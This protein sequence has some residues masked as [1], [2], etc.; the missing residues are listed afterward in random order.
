MNITLSS[1]TT[2]E[3]RPS[4]RPARR[5]RVLVRGADHRGQ[6]ERDL[7]GARALF[8]RRRSRPKL[9]PLAVASSP[10]ANTESRRAS[11]SSRPPNT[12]S[13]RC[14]TPPSSIGWGVTTAT[15]SSR[16]PG[17]AEAGGDF[18]ELRVDFDV[19]FFDDDAGTRARAELRAFF[20]AARLS[21]ARPPRSL[22][23][24]HREIVR[25]REIV[26]AVPHL[27]P[28]VEERA[29]VRGD[30]AAPAEAS[31]AVPAPSSAARRQNTAPS[32]APRPARTAV[33]RA[34]SPPSASPPCSRMTKA[35]DAEHAARD[36]LR[37]RRRRAGAEVQAAP[38]GS[39]RGLALLRDTRRVVR[40]GAIRGGRAVRGVARL[41]QVAHVYLRARLGDYARAQVVRLAGAGARSPVAPRRRRRRVRVG[42][43]QP[44]D[45]RARVRGGGH[46]G[47]HREGHR[48]AC[49]ARSRH[50]A[51][52]LSPRGSSA[53]QCDPL[54]GVP[55][56]NEMR[57]PR[58]QQAVSTFLVLCTTISQMKIMCD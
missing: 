16:R 41:L 46:R 57:L 27:V 8:Q 52:P 33:C 22:P 44:R 18:D 47:E 12:T 50:R 38:R 26:P 24:E 7:R 31:D 2:A 56:N 23:V 20:V 55:E 36:V 13:A 19:D 17:E 34:E 5:A 35:G 28:T 1:V 32:G 54:R 11:D 42:P 53:E 43:L 51:R 14:F 4:G 45:G 3:A 25:V 6:V 29:V 10:S 37:V 21:H 49:R 39:H 30:A 58:R 40:A 15:C 48:T 9:A